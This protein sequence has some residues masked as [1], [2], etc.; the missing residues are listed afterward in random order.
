MFP[1]RASIQRTRRGPTL[2]L[3]A[4]AAALA[5]QPP[6]PS[7]QVRGLAE[8]WEFRRDQEPPGPGFPAELLD[9]L[10]TWLPA[11]I[12]GTIHTDLL[13][14]G[15]IPDPFWRDQE[16]RLQWIGEEDWVYRNTFEV[17][18]ALLEKEVV[19]LVFHGLDTFAD[20]LLNDQVILEAN[21]MFRTWTV[22][23]TD[24]V[25]PGANALEVR[26]RS[27]LP[28]A[29]EARAALPYELPAGN[30]RGDPPSRV[31]V[32]KA[33]YHYGWDWGPR[34]VTSGIW[35]PVELRGWSGARLRDLQLVTDS[36][37]ENEAFLRGVVEVDVSR[38]EAERR[39]AG[40]G[41]QAT[42]TLV[43]PEGAF[44]P[45]GQSITLGEGIQRFTIPIRISNKYF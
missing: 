6:A 8:G 20:V 12:P 31:F 13:A 22:E 16:L 36:I 19:E 9:T 18:S 38:E 29:L 14:S 41:V 1:I 42:L 27:P 21:N 37:Q 26:F 39:A 2:L 7:V 11:T 3:L 44:Q 32:R 28:P 17:S 33:A 10:S 30:D 25:R 4:T 34:F 35:R 24:L 15:I 5:C 23:V 43:S 45:V 40:G